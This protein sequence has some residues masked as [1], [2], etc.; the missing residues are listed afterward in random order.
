VG[1]H[2]FGRNQLRLTDHIERGLHTEQDG[3]SRRPAKRANM[4][5][6]CI[7]PAQ[8][9]AARITPKANSTAQHHT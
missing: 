5:F 8:H 4:S 9:K 1:V 6:A 7:G 3:N 2:A